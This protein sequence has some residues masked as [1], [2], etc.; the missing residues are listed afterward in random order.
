MLKIDNIFVAIL[1]SYALS[2]LS[3]STNA[4]NTF[5]LPGK[6]E[7]AMRTRYQDVQDNWLGDA[8]AF[9]TRIKLTSSFELDDEQQWQFLVEPNFV[10]AFND[11]D[12]NSVTVKKNTSPIPDPQGFNWSKVNLSFDSDNDW[13]MTL[14]RQTLSFDNE[15]MVGA[16]EIW[17]T[18]QTFDALAFDYNDHINW[19]VQYAYSTQVNR[20]FGR[21]STDTIPKD[22]IRYGIVYQRPVNELG[23]H[24]LNGH[25]LNVSYQTENNLTLTSYNYL[26]ENKSQAKFSLNT[27]GLRIADEFKPKSIKYRYTI[28]FASQQDAFDNPDNYRAWYSLL[29]TSIQY[30]S[31][32]FQVSQEIISEDDNNGFKT[33]LGTNHKFQ[34]W[35]DIFTGY[36]MQTGIR[37]QYLTYKGRFKKMRWRAVYHRF[38]SYNN[39][40]HIG[41]EF[42]VE[43][44]YRLTRKW[45]LKFV[46]A[47]YQAKDGL[48]YFPKANNDLTTWYASIAYNI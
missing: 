10:Y 38:N 11:G 42:D 41:N 34:G 21:D 24:E 12:Y 2:L 22:D 13:Q 37:D 39:G 6:H 7:F 32:Q 30:K 16:I 8:Q 3:L 25:F 45:E 48:K 40:N 20:I 9:T 46:Y 4:E 18:P 29:Q 33:P 28:E 31:H 35:A 27:F 15:R 5:D 14:G 19:R 26:V 43:L 44:A 17:Q 23:V 36:A 47:D 1:L